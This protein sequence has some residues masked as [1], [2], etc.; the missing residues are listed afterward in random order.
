MVDST[1]RI[2]LLVFWVLSIS[3]WQNGAIK[4]FYTFDEPLQAAPTS[5]SWTPGGGG[6]VNVVYNGNS[7][8]GCE[9]KTA[10]AGEPG[11]GYVVVLDPDE[12]WVALTFALEDITFAD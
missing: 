12:G 10:R 3:G 6:S 1:Q 9:V 11:T 7:Y 4:M 5:V 8:T 2:K